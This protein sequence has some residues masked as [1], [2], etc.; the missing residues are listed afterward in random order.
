MMDEKD[1]HVMP[2]GVAATGP[3]PD[4]VPHGVLPLTCTT[5]SEATPASL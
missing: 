3:T 2:A 5:L 1:T 4:G